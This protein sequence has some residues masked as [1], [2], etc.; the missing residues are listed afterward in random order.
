MSELRITQFVESIQNSGLPFKIWKIIVNPWDD[1]YR[2]EIIDPFLD[3][4]SSEEENTEGL[5]VHYKNMMRKIQSHNYGIN[6]EFQFTFASDFTFILKSIVSKYLLQF[7]AE[8]I[9]AN[10]K[11]VI[12]NIGWGKFYDD[13]RIL[14]EMVNKIKEWARISKFDKI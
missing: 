9:D 5:D 7:D 4:A 12:E 8:I 14:D 11:F 1:E 13:E 6:P 3:P 10:L 2:I